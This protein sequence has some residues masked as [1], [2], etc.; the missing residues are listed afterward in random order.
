MEC[1]RGAMA[2]S[3]QMTQVLNAWVTSPPRLR[4]GGLPEPLR[5]GDFICP[6]CGVATQESAGYVTCPKCGGVLN[7]FLHELVELNPHL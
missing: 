6:R 2:L 4:K 3:V 1:A 7:E 5:W